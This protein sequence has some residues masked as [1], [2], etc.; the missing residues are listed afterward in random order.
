MATFAGIAAIAAFVAAVLM[1][2]SSVLGNSDG[3]YSDGSSTS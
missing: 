2:A 1:L 3:D